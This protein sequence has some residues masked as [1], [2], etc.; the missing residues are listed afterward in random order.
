MKHP[1]R[2]RNAVVAALGALASNAVGTVGLRIDAARL[3]GAIPR[4]IRHSAGIVG[5]TTLEGPIIGGLSAGL[6]AAEIAE[7][8][9][10]DPQRVKDPFSANAS[11][12]PVLWLWYWPPGATTTI[13]QGGPFVKEEAWPGWWIREGVNMNAWFMNLDA[14]PL[15]TGTIMSA[16]VEIRGD[17][18]ND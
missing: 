8:F 16:V 12:R 15:T 11:Q 2:V 10:A 7:W 1:M 3:Q 6:N 14:V 17:W 9:V 13:G 5:K 18:I 4:E